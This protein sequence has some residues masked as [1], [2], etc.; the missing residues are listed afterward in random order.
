MQIEKK[1]NT[2]KKLRVINGILVAFITLPIWYVLLYRILSAISATELTWFLYWIYVP[3][4]CI[5]S[6]LGRIIEDKV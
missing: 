1:E 6:V 4:A 3:V 5:T 2:M